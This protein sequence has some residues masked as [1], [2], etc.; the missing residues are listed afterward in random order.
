METLFGIGAVF[1]S[2]LFLGAACLV[3]G[4]KR[5]YV[6]GQ[7]DLEQHWMT[8]EGDVQHEREKIQREEGR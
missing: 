3:H 1:G 2:V 5:G 7:R 6:K 8:Q 4:Y